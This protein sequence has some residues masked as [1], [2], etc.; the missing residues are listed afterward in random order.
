MK[1]FGWEK[2][3]L[4]GHSLGAFYSFIYATMAPDT[5]DM[6]ICIDCVLM[7]KFDSDI[8][9]ESF[10]RN[11]DQHMAQDEILASGS[12]REP[13]SYKLPKLGMAVANGTLNSV[14]PELAQ[15]RSQD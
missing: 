4:M 3:S 6:V 2:V 9:L 1:H 7:P 11:L 13:P 5:V 14:T 15:G 12:L 8:A 10:R